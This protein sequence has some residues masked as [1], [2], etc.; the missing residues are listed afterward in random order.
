[1]PQDLLQRETGAALSY[2]SGC[3]D[4]SEY[5]RRTLHAL[6]P[7]SAGNPPHELLHAVN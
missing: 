2:E 7:G 1:M 6:K 3:E 5:V 4:V